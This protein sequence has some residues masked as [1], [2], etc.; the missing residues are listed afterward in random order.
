MKFI[1]CILN[2]LMLLQ[3]E[4]Q[5][6]NY[7]VRGKVKIDAE[8]VWAELGGKQV[9]LVSDKQ[10]YAALATALLPPAIDAARAIVNEKMKQRLEQYS[11]SYTV[12]VS[13]ASFWENE[14]M[15]LLPVIN[16][17]RQVKPKQDT[18]A[19]E[20]LSIELQPELS[21]D[22][23]AFRFRLE[24]P[25]LYRYA[26]VRTRGRYDYIN[27][28]L[29]IQFN[30]LIV[31]KDKYEFRNLRTTHLF[32]PMQKPGSTWLPEGVSICSGWIP[33]PPRPAIAYE[34]DVAEKEYKTVLSS[35][36]KSGKSLDDSVTTETTT[37]QLR[38]RDYEVLK[39]KAGLYEMEIT[40]HEYNPFKVKA[41]ARQQIF[42]NSSE[43]L[44]DLLQ[45]I[46]EE[47]SSKSK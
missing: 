14:N 35:G 7:D 13:G 30:A 33:F 8:R 42:S 22:G 31:N 24:Q 28:D 41:A 17:H 36:R 39:R 9:A 11:Q 1:L 25:I 12:S 45:S 3:A 15:L 6:V 47:L 18:N 26:A 2:G 29:E 23:T 32:I 44:G 27:L 21:P 43:S 40:V 37:L 10:G 5:L 16:I 46:T 4:A 38:G 20:A 19:L 34:A